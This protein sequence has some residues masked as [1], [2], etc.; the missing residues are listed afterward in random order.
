MV[1]VHE[2]ARPSPK[3]L[4]L[5]SICHRPRTVTK[6]LGK[7]LENMGPI[8]DRWPLRADSIRLSAVD[9]LTAHQ[10]DA[11]RDDNHREKGPVGLSQVAGH[12]VEVAVADM[13]V[14]LKAVNNL[15]HCSLTF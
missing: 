3:R 11:R 13:K 1:V 8:N 10:D 2:E 5:G 14:V 9:G 12:T 15:I 4:N 7:S 6:A